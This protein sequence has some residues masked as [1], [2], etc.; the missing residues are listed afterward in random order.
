[1]E[2]FHLTTPQQNIWNLQKYY[3]GTAVS[4][5]CGAVFYNEKR[6]SKLLQQSI[7]LFI[8]KHSAI[9]LRFFEKEGPNQYVAEQ[10]D[11]PIPIMTFSS[12]EEFDSFAEKF[13]KKPLELFDQPMY[14]FI[15][16]YV[17]NKSG[18]LVLL[19]H[20][21]SDAWTF[22][23]LA[24]QLDEAY[25]QLKSGTNILLLE[26][27]YINY[28]QSADAYLRS[29]RY[30]KD[31]EYWEKKYSECPEESPAK[32]YA[33]SA[34]SIAA[35]RITESLSPSLEQKIEKYCVANSVTQAVLFETALIIYLSRINLKNRTVTIGV[36]IL[37]RSSAKE[38]N[39]AGMFVT[40][41][42]LTI[43][44]ADEMTA[45]ELSKQITREHI[46]LFRHQKYPYS[47]ILK[48]LREKRNFLGN[49]YDVMIS[50]QNAKT[51][52]A[53]DT[54][55]YCNGYSEIPLVIHIDNR[56]EKDCHTLN[57]DYQE[58]VFHDETEI[59]YL[60]KRLEFIL[61]QIVTN[62][63]ITIKDICII[64][65]QEKEKIVYEFNNTYADYPK[66]KCIHELFSKQ[67]AL[68]P[69]ETALVFWDERF[70]Y[71]Q[72]DTMSDSL[73]HFLRKKGVGRNDIVPIIAVRSWHVIVAMLGVLKAGG[74]YMPVDPYYPKDRIEGMI[75]AAK[76]KIALLYGVELKCQIQ[77]VD[78]SHFN[79]A[80]KSKI[81]NINQSEDAAYVIFTSGSTGVPKGITVCHRNV[82]NYSYNNSHNS[83]CHAIIQN[84][85]ESIVSVTNIVFDI[86]ATESILPLLNGMCIYFASDDETASQRK[87][88]KL[89]EQNYIDV[90]QTTPTKMKSYI[91]DKQNTGYLQKIKAIILG[92]E[93]LPLELYHE[94]RSYTDAKIYNIY[95]PAETTV[96]STNAEITG[97][98]VTI[99]R[100]IANTQI[101]IL[102][103]YNRPLPIGVAGELCIAGDG[104]GK[105]YINRPDLT[106]ER[107]AANPFADKKNHHG[108]T[109]YHTGDLARWRA[110]GEIEYLGRIDTQVKIRGLRVEL[111]EIENVLSSFK[112]INLT[113]VVDKYDENGRQYLAGYYT[114]DM[115]LDE[116]LL[117]GHLSAKLPKYM[118]PNYF[119]RLEKMPMT[120]S[121]KIDRKNLPIPDFSLQKTEY[122]EPLT[123]TEIK[124]AAIWQKLLGVERV[125]RKDYF[126]ELGGDSLLAIAM[127]N[128]IEK[129][130]GIEISIRDIM[131]KSS[132]EQLSE[133][134]EQSSTYN[135]IIA[136]HE[137]KYILLPQQ[138]A[139]YA[140]CHKYPDTL[141]Y[142]MPAKISL[143]DNIDRARL[144]QGICR[145]IEQHKLLKSHIEAGE[146]EIFGIYDENAEIKFEEYENE[147]EKSFVR[148]FNLGNAPLIH[149]GFTENAM[150]FDI[151][152]IIA[153][154]SSLNIILRDIMLAYDGNT[155]PKAEVTYLD[156]AK[157]F[158]SLN[159]EEHKAFYK[160]LL[161]CD[162]EPLLLLKTKKVEYGGKSKEYQIP[163][164]AF[165]AAKE[166]AKKNKLTE[167]M[168][169]LGAYGI[170]LSK[171]TAKKDILSSI[172]L[173]NRVH[174]DT[175]DMVGMFV[176]TLP[177]HL[178][179]EGDTKRYLSSVREMML[180][181][182]RYQE[183]PFW[184]IANAV[185]M[186]DKSVIN[187]S[188]VYQGDGEK[189]LYLC[190]QRLKPQMIDTCTAKFDL[191]LELTPLENGGK[192][193]LEYNCEK[194]DEQLIDALAEAYIRILPQ[195]GKEKIADVSVLSEK[196][197][198]K[199]IEEFNDTYVCYPQEKCVHELFSN[200]AACTPEKAALVFE[201]K[202]LTYRELDELS[203]SLACFLR[204][205][206]VGRNDIV[207]IIARRSWHVVVAMLGVIK[208]G[209]AYMLIDYQY[210]KDRIDYLIKESGA[211]ITLVYGYNKKDSVNLEIIEQL[212]HKGVINNI[213]KNSDIFCVIH[214][215]GSTG[216]PK[217]TALTHA[218]V[219][220]CIENTRNLFCASQQTIST[221]IITFDAFIQETIVALCNNVSVVLLNEKQMTQFDMFEEQVEKYEK[222]FLF[223]TPTKLLTYIKNSKTKEFINHIEAFVLGGEVFTKE[224]YEYLKE[225]KAKNVFNEYGPTETT[226]YATAKK[227]KNATDITIGKPVN[228]TQV[229]I[230]DQDNQPL[231][232]GVAGELCIAGNGVGKGYIN[233]PELTEKSFVSNPFAAENNHH[234]K[235]MYRTGDLAC[236]REDGELEYMGRI[237]T[238]VKIRGLRIEPGEI[239]NIMG[240]Y[241][242]IALT[243][244]VDRRD[245]NNRQ[246]LVGYYTSC[247]EIDEKKLRSHLSAKLPKYMVPNY[248]MRLE[249]MPMTPSGKIDKKN[250]PMSN[251]IVERSEYLVPKTETERKLCQLLQELL[252]IKQFGI[253]DDFFEFGGDSLTAIEYVAK[254]HNIGIDFNLQNVFD[255]PTVQQLCNF[256][257][258]G[259]KERIHY[260]ASY[261]DKY[262]S[263]LAE[264][265]I[266]EA[267]VP[268]KKPLGNVL[269]TGA[270]GF[271]G[272]HV[273]DMLMKEETGKIYCLVRNSDTDG[274]HEKIHE[275][276][277]YYF[278]EKYEAEFGKRIFLIAGDIERD[279]LA[280]HMPTDVQTIIHT[281]ASVK[282]YGSYNYFYR[283]N[284]EGT[285]HVVDYAKKTGARLIHISTVSV[286]G[287]S[288]ADD[289]TVYRSDEEKYFYETSLYINQ[290]LDNVYVRSKFEAELAVY[291]SILEG[292]NAKIIRVGNLTN[293]V[294]D[295][296]FQPNYTQNAFLTRVKAALEFGLF[297][298]YL[299]PLYAEF[300][301]IDL[302]AEG[303]IKIAQY[304]D[305]Q[306]VFHLNSNFPIYFD[307]LLE[308]VHELGISMRVVSGEVF[309]EALEQT[310]R[311][312]GT[313]YIYEAFQNDM[314]KQGRL[315][316]DSNI[317]IMNDFTV[318]FLKKVGFEWNK[319]DFEYIKGYLEYFRTIG[320]LDV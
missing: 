287:N 145:V 285:R 19:S 68:M 224:L 180:G 72:L 18:I 243:A 309:H 130:F 301:P 239:E 34:D 265:V 69:E 152:H 156:Y 219:A 245:E 144:K 163:K 231:P 194:Y 93:A 44:V 38:K 193:R 244:V 132:L 286:S 296:R 121:G 311:S 157:Y 143:P 9:R 26:S 24:N 119:M 99:G 262:R 17:E 233:R 41:L 189:T 229:Y 79:F 139:I 106:A 187:T 80:D 87:L 317:H 161:N 15:V 53:A 242:G 182:F 199:I 8:Q 162:F 3:E 206:R 204:E 259:K 134:I 37:N 292:L 176:N 54:K 127:L 211:N 284:V 220:H 125:G 155:L 52:S 215:S 153:D 135:Q 81:E 290:P 104:V 295:Y 271:L 297:P 83:V 47:N 102:D 88:S 113:A 172:I 30:D 251:F 310:I 173:Q 298:E 181:L 45:L 73:A 128:E 283:I 123:D 90:I 255:Y 160:R 226:V 277:R 49:P 65:K 10:N 314:D 184:D 111:G 84:Q 302:T 66:E 168:V 257:E 28:I 98:D 270:T 234:G 6:D 126:F 256:M 103:S 107:F 261:F 109:L 230:L 22:G 190:G 222:S 320:Y 240:N 192:I 300:S 276:L 178:A 27:D 305:K 166:F 141:A 307:R 7:S 264:N 232:I 198:H 315:V 205:K 96:W 43:A 57:V 273:L 122:V 202:K 281:A 48:N 294:S 97:D 5:L 74:A 164:E 40:T 32:L 272:A 246:Y 223:S 94:L 221:T 12:M 213:N 280:E 177:I 20:L 303:I 151:H 70:T 318:W 312:N 76:S 62:H 248:F 51:H 11:E 186:Q 252:H 120:P 42:P 212:Q 25:H 140:F 142:N 170:L 268:E 55:W 319:T 21:I 14:R 266:N 171:Y 293:R 308:I 116:K 13:A 210:P 167:T 278:G 241:E 306:N 267:F 154:G 250:L 91:Q 207:P 112:G 237:D 4:N 169:F 71:K 249:K 137:N 117:R 289:F 89:V 110:D 291:D 282:H 39:T 82:C 67:A 29:A 129:T 227:I 236:W 100:P 23:L 201:D 247:V 209:G 214:T 115:E 288:M 150:L 275:V 159:T 228:N 197:Y 279:G 254:A 185:G 147:Q 316:Y 200:R 148:P 216:F 174:T 124:L 78:L 101:Y 253:T 299:L 260:E 33:L 64:T 191:T 118:V 138:K 60:I 86:F 131:E 195:L 35:K 114:S 146:D 149:I 179:V 75:E 203:N 258:K 77:T 105:G 2:Y 59:V 188:F 108:K 61:G 136:Y 235:V 63:E 208:A 95:G 56:D 274:H 217:V 31:R 175:K 46:D 183:L 304:A 133:C 313:E 269:L 196:E 1:M 165:D 16:F 238:Q 58:K 158:Y 225:A 218:N 92:G 36:P 50:Y 263:I 85:Y